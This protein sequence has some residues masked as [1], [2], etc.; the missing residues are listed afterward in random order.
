M[1]EL[2]WQLELIP[3]DEFNSNNV[4]DIVYSFPVAC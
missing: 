4:L 2:K 1:G 3:S